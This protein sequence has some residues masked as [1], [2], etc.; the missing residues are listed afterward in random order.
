MQQQAHVWYRT[1][2]HTWGISIRLA[3]TLSDLAHP[4][5]RPSLDVAPGLGLTLAPTCVRLLDDEL[6]CLVAGL[7][8]AA[9]ALRQRYPES[10]WLQCTVQH[11]LFAET[12][13]Q[14]EGFACAMLLWA[15]AVGHYAVHV[16]PARFDPATNRYRFDFSA[17]AHAG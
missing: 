17:Y 11:L 2:A 13:V 14:P 10:A 12:D 3:A 15:G 7:R 16:P 6:H 8:W 4:V 1:I 9:P 5:D